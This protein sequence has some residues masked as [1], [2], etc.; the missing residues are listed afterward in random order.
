MDVT[1]VTWK[2]KG[3]NAAIQVTCKHVCRAFYL[4]VRVRRKARWGGNSQQ[5][6]ARVQGVAQEMVSN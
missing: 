3:G 6:Q 1:Y 5:Y 4:G 2:I